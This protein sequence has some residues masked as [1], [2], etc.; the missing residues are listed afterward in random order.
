MTDNLGEQLVGV[1]SEVIALT[2]S[3]TEVKG[4]PYAVYDMTTTPMRTK[5]GEYGA[6]GETRIRIVSDNP[7][8]ID[9]ISTSIKDAIAS[10]MR[11]ETY[12]SRLDNETKEC[13]DGIWTIELNYTL[14]EY[15]NN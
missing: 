15:F 7:I 11:N 2:L 3:E 4:Y 14:K 13:A 8:E 12:Y 5:E 10:G 6:S 9:V 1:L